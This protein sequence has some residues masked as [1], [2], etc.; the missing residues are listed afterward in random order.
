MVRLFDS[1]LCKPRFSLKNMA[2]ESWLLT[3][4]SPGPGSE[5]PLF[6]RLGKGRDDGSLAD[7][8]WL[9]VRLM[10]E[11]DA[12]YYVIY[13]LCVYDVN[14]RYMYTCFLVVYNLH[15]L[16]CFCVYRYIYYIYVCTC[17]CTYVYAHMYMHICVHMFLCCLFFL[18][19]IHVGELFGGLWWFGMGNII[20]ISI[21]F[22]LL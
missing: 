7:L 3:A 22:H 19:C 2:T 21:I 17:I 20:Y 16:M 9:V 15:M 13:C 10:C 12:V 6:S 14:L 8:K 4:M 11:Y 5:G 18:T 1:S